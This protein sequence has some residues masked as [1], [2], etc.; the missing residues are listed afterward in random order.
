MT[1]FSGL[2]HPTLRYSSHI[3]SSVFKKSPFLAIGWPRTQN[4]WWIYI[5]ASNYNRYRGGLDWNLLSIMAEKEEVTAPQI[6]DPLLIWTFAP[7]L[8]KCKW[9]S[10]TR[11]AMCLSFERQSH[12]ALRCSFATAI[13]MLWLPTC[14]RISQEKWPRGW[15]KPGEE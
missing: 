2:E 13:M 12:F 11:V 3:K 7:R 8:A 1:M 9:C 14:V 10:E 5:A 15:V 6:N 4:C